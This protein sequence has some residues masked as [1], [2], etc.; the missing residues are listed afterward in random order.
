MARSLQNYPELTAG[1]SSAADGTMA[2]QG[3]FTNRQYYLQ[4]H[5]ID[6]RHAVHAG[7]CHGA[8]TAI[9][10]AANGG[11]IISETDGLITTE[12][13]LGLAMTAADCLL[14]SVYDPTEKVIGLVHAGSKGLAQEVLTRFLDTWKKYFPLNPADLMIDISPSICPEHYTVTSEQAKNFT[15]WLDACQKR[16]ALVHLDLR[17]IARQQLVDGGVTPGNISVSPQCTFEDNN[18][19]SYR[20]DH[21]TEPQL[22]IGYLM[23]R[24]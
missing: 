10:T 4:Q 13:D 22:Q 8:Q 3:G 5:D 9:V 18:L 14:L 21:P 23:R 11:S 1:F 17:K 20:R 16:G 24:G 15:K 19:F 2:L 12:T 7:L 6:P